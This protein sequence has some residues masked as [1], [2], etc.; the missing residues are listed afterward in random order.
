MAARGSNKLG[1]FRVAFLGTHIFVTDSIANLS[2]HDSN[3]ACLK[4]H[5]SVVGAAPAAGQIGF[6]NLSDNAKFTVMAKLEPHR[7]P[8]TEQQP[9]IFVSLQSLFV[10]GVN[11]RIRRIVRLCP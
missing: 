6:G 1:H 4:L 2:V 3:G 7:D 9:N 11:C 5:Y 10:C 8:S